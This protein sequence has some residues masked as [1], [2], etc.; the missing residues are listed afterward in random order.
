M[1][2]RAVYFN[3]KFLSQKI[4]GVQRYALE[5]LLELDQLSG[6]N[7]GDN[8]NVKYIILAPKDILP[9]YKKIFTNI[10]VRITKYN[11]SVF[12]E[13][14]LLPIFS[15][16]SLLINLCNTAPIFKINQI[17]TIHDVSPIVYPEAFSF[18]FSLYYKILFYSYGFL[19]FKILTVSNFSRS[20][21]LKYIPTIKDINI[22][23]I[24]NG[25][26]H[27]NLIEANNDV[28]QDLALIDKQYFLIVGS[29]NPLK[30]ISKLS[31]IISKHYSNSDFKFV[32]VG[33]SNTKIFTTSNLYNSNNIILAG[34]IPDAKLKALYL[35]CCALIFPSLY[36]G[37]GIPLIE[38]VTF[39]CPIIASDIPSTREI[40]GDLPIYFNPKSEFDI[41]SKLSM[42]MD[43]KIQSTRIK[44]LKDSSVFMI[45]ESVISSYNWNASA[46]LLLSFINRNIN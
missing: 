38:A 6:I 5:L 29:L 4:T 20:Q 18:L 27:L 25:S 13:Q 31:K 30:N 3:G 10:E 1:N 32:F 40:C 14:V 8:L 22:T 11:S 9:H 21:I 24:Y 26:E 23:V 36:E 44:N 33:S 2:N 45:K 28:L 12:W 19:K 16:K 41:C 7:V 34:F 37:F 35:G 42:F 43:D 15:K 17:A 39:N 46:K